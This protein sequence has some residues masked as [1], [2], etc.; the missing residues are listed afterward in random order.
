MSS[1][2]LSRSEDASPARRKEAASWGRFP[3]AAQEHVLLRGN[4][5]AL[6]DGDARPL[7]P[8]GNG[9]SYG[10]TCLNDGG[11]LLDCRGM[12]R[13]LGF[14]TDTGVIRVEA[15]VLLGDII[16]MALPAGWF[17]PVTPGTRFVTVGGAIANDVHGKN[18]HVAGTFGEHV[19]RFEL[20]RSDGTRRVCCPT[21]NADWMRATIGGMGLTGVITW[22]EIQ[23]RRVGGGW[24]D[25]STVKLNNLADYFAIAD[26]SDAGFEYTVAWIDSLAG[27]ASLGRGHL[28]RANHSNAPGGRD[29]R[30][31]EPWLSVPFTPPI[32][33]LNRFNL[34]LF[35][36]AMYAKQRRRE[37]AAKVPFLKFF[38]PLDGV[39]RWNRLY[40]PRGL[41][42]H[43]SIIP[44]ADAR[45]A[46]TD[47][48]KLSARSGAGSFLTVL[49][50][51]GD[52]PAAGILSF[53]RGGVTLTLDF[54]NRGAR[55]ETL[56]TELDR[57]T[58]AAGG[59][60]NPYKDG[61]MSAA[62]YA[63]SFPRWRE[64]L[65]FKDPRFSSSFW[66]RVTA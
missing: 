5:P 21:E 65:P 43:Q 18:H 6:P 12:N 59:A 29:V 27:G 55:T 49:K 13:V 34:K 20:L 23:L 24:L 15:G 8:Y 2:A 22:A 45:E 11:I 28:M 56:L 64:I 31:G 19:R 10:D 48:L 26:E 60:V 44:N 41:M 9:R 50:R 37:V 33:V 54:A 1:V 51:F 62:T 58:V 30:I 46:I 63:A 57:I 35:N 61:R 40:G 17:L 4:A 53:P 16:A 52:R 3:R 47:M 42:Q 7:L 36:G 39:G 66:R 32:P 14:H 25:Q 38:Y